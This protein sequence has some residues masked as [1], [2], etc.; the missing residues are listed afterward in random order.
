MRYEHTSNEDMRKLA[1]AIREMPRPAFEKIAPAI[2]AG[3][4]MRT[5]AIIHWSVWLLTVRLRMSEYDA[6]SFI[7]RRMSGKLFNDLQQR[8][9]DHIQHGKDA[10]DSRSAGG[11]CAEEVETLV[12]L[13]EAGSLMAQASRAPSSADGIDRC[14]KVR[15]DADLPVSK[16]D[17]PDF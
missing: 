3:G 10:Y 11:L 5:N 13:M 14:P 15:T 6:W 12:E 8:T 2:M 9:A 1:F 17:E 4:L 16:P 7:N